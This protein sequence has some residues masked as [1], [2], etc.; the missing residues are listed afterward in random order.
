MASLHWLL[1][2]GE[3]QFGGAM[4]ERKPAMRAS[5]CH[6]H[7]DDD[8]LLVIAGRRHRQRR[9]GAEVMGGDLVANLSW[10]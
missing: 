10:R 7:G 2:L 1:L 8:R 5:V 6:G 9:E 4:A 3:A